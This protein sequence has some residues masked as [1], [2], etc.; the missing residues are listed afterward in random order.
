MLPPQLKERLLSGVYGISPH[1]LLINSAIAS[2][3]GGGNSDGMPFLHLVRLR[4][5]CS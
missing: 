4:L 3:G 2:V 1:T 5:T